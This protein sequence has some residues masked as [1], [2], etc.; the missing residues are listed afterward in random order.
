LRT[1]DTGPC[2]RFPR[3]GQFHPLRYLAGLAAAIEAR[4]G[5]LFGATHAAHVEGG[6]PGHVRTNAGASVTAGAI[7]IATNTPVFDRVVLHTKQAPYMSYVVALRIPRGSV[8][9]ALFWDTADPFHYVRVRRGV[10]GRGTGRRSYDTLIVGGED[11]KTAQA[12]DGTVRFARL[13]QWA[14]ARF[15]RA[16]RLE[17]QWSG[18]IMESADGLAFIG[19]NPMDS[20]NV[21]VASGD[22][23]LG[24]TH[25]TIAG[26]LLTDLIIGRRNAWASLYD[27]SRVPL[28]A[29]A[30][31]VRE[32]VNVA[33]QYTDWLT[34]GDVDSIDAIKPASGAIVRRGMKKLAVYRDESGRVHRF[35]AVC[36]HLGCVVAWNGADKSWDCPCHGSR[37]DCLGK[38]IN[39][40]ANSD[41]KPDVQ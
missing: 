8:P 18:Q 13:E 1:F 6:P 24:M 14:R 12:D 5:Q 22:S 17:A 23:G 10:P 2:L 34:G 25:G 7:V 35:S 11:H 3:Q 19:P 39:G 26:I 15:P 16:G 37:F 27:P 30:T 9:P 4:R 36:P 41:L 38:V 32:N 40:P 33:A 21:Y 29:S 28:A 20:P 31:L